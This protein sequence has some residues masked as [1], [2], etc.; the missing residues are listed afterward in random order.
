MS[1]ELK[2]PFHDLAMQLYSKVMFEKEIAKACGVGKTAIFN[3]RR[4]NA[5][6]PHGIHSPKNFKHG[7]CM[8]NPRLYTVWSSMK[9]R[10]E[11]P[12]REKY[13]DYGARGIT[14]CKAWHDP[15]AFIDWAVTSGY[16]PG[17]QL[18]R[19]DND[20]GYCPENC[21]WVTPKQNSN[22]RRSNQFITISGETKTISAWASL[23]GISPNTLYSERREKG[24]EC[25][26]QTIIKALGAKQIGKV[27]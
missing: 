10:C 4:K 6:P 7:A 22:N 3:W 17:L 14:V 2:A 8:A 24:S 13:K 16:K 27:A 26:K 23:T 19:K 18:D 9:H 11:D 20:K 1:E 12:K 25:V 15:M 5:L 21:H